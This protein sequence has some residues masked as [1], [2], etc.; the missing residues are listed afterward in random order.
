LRLEQCADVGVVTFLHGGS[1]AVAGVVDQHIDATE[2][3][4]GLPDSVSDLGGVGDVEGQ[5][6]NA[7]GVVSRQVG[8]LVDVACGDSRV[9]TCGDH[10]LGQGA[11]Q[12]GGASGD[13][14][15]GH[16]IVSFC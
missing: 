1:V 15:S 4:L 14:P 5:W 12:S 9:V 13:E 3:R 8:D 11:T 7:V 10:R 6:E 16:V 2:L